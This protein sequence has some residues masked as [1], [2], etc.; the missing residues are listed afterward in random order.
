VYAY[1]RS[2]NWDTRIAAGQAIDNIAANAPL[3]DPEILPPEP[4]GKKGRV[5][6][7]KREE[8]KEKRKKK[9]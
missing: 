3:W 7:E 6:R 5:R 2:K 8:K 4:A 9:K 1:L